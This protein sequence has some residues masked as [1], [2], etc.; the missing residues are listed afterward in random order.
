MNKPKIIYDFLCRLEPITRSSSAQPYACIKQA[1]DVDD[2]NY[3]R[4][5]L[6][7]TQIVFDVVDFIKV[8]HLDNND[9]KW[10]DKLIRLL[11]NTPHDHQT[12][13]NIT[14][15]LF[16]DTKLFIQSQIRIWDLVNSRIK[17]ISEDNIS[18]LKEDT[19]LLIENIIKNYELD[20]DVKAFII[21]KL[22][23]IINALDHY[24]IYGNEGLIEILEQ[25]IGHT[26]TNK[27]YQGFMK[28]E[29]SKVWH[30]Y[31]GKFSLVIATSE[32]VLSI[33]T[34]LH[35]LLP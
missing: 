33:G 35:N 30:E 4:C 1:L 3:H 19:T 15:S 17:N 32:S 21:K 12:F 31:L 20:D 23:S 6:K 2:S 22:R 28:S 24:H 7:L 18:K 5:K 11:S 16:P 10:E 29:N 34:T 14:R 25:A 8:D 13:I 9:C 26:F 27:N